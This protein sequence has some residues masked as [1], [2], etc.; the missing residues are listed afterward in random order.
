MAEDLGYTSEQIR[1]L[2]DGNLTLLDDD[3]RQVIEYVN[4]VMSRSVTDEQFAQ[5]VSDSV[6]S[7]WSR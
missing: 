3:D 1:G 6:T 2:R 4:A 5:C 7:G